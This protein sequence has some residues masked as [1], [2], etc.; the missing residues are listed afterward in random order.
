MKRSN[1]IRYPVPPQID[2]NPDPAGRSARNRVSHR[3]DDRQDDLSWYYPAPERGRSVTRGAR[4]SAESDEQM[5]Y[6]ISQRRGPWRTH[7]EFIRSAVG[8]LIRLVAEEGDDSDLLAGVRTTEAAFDVQRVRVQGQR[9]D[10]YFAAVLAQAQALVEGGQKTRARG[11]LRRFQRDTQTVRTPA[12]K[13]ARSRFLGSKEVRKIMG[14][15]H[16]EEQ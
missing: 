14:D 12:Y 16:P 3:L 4:I 2:P 15:A 7:S 10:H 9:L 1:V 8:V 6:I 13:R 11:F 5:E